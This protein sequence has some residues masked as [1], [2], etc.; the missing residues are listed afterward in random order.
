MNVSFFVQFFLFYHNFWP[1]QGKKVKN[2]HFFWV[3]PL[4]NLKKLRNNNS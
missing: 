2:F 1:T 4:A 3:Y